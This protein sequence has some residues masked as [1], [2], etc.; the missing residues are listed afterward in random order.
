MEKEVCPVCNKIA[1]ESCDVCGNLF[2]TLCVEEHDH[3]PSCGGVG[4]YQHIVL[5]DTR[6]NLDYLNGQST[7][8]IVREHCRRCDGSGIE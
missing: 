3:C 5:R 8:E 1:T 4:E 6:G 7:G 2:C